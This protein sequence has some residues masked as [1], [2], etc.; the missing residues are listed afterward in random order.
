[1]KNYENE[2]VVIL[3]GANANAIVNGKYRL[4]N[5]NDINKSNVDTWDT[6]FYKALI[7]AEKY[8]Y[9]RN[10]FQN[11]S[12][13]FLTDEYLIFPNFSLFAI[14]WFKKISK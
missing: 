2:V 6:N 10:K 12:I 9:N 14:K 4:L 5:L 1:M 8:I 13:L 11:K 3:F 7:E